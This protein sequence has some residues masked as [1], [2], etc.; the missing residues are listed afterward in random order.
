M[1]ATLV[2]V[3]GLLIVVVSLIVEHGLSSY[4]ML[5]IS[6]M[7]VTLPPCYSGSETEE[8]GEG[9]SRTSRRVANQISQM[10]L[11]GVRDEAQAAKTDRVVLFKWEARV[12]LC[13]VT[14]GL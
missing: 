11:E 10:K 12:T 1:G 5:Y 7:C 8:A 6:F 3:C 13:G 9:V 4:S 14:D 2:A